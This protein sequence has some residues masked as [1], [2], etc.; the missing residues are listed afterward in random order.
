MK[1][2]NKG[3]KGNN[4]PDARAHTLAAV[5]NISA[6]FVKPTRPTK[7]ANSTK[8]YPDGTSPSERSR[9]V[10]ASHQVGGISKMD[11]LGKECSKGGRNYGGGD[12]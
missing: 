5:A 6:F 4:F 8:G 11:E 2:G 7:N 9:D 10:H 3:R 1:K 12:S